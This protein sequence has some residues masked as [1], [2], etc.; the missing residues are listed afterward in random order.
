[1]LWSKGNGQQAHTEFEKSVPRE[2]ELLP[3]LGD[4][5]SEPLGDR[6]SVHGCLE[7]AEHEVQRADVLLRFQRNVFFQ[8]AE[9]ALIQNG[10]YTCQVK[11]KK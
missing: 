7:G 4:D 3:R 9:S 2:A 5:W 8:T 10:C 1:M 11:E 6:P